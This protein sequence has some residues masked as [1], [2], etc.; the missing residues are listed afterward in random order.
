MTTRPLMLSRLLALLI[1]SWLLATTTP[2]RADIVPSDDG[3]LGTTM[4]LPSNALVGPAQKA[5]GWVY[6]G[7]CEQGHWTRRLF[8]NLPRCDRPGGMPGFTI[9][10]W[11]GSVVRL[12]PYG[13]P[14][15]RLSAGYTAKL[16]ST[17][18]RGSHVWGEITI[19]NIRLDQAQQSFGYV[20]MGTCKD[21]RWLTQAFRFMPLCL[22][23][24]ISDSPFFVGGRLVVSVADNPV[25]LHLPTS[26]PAA[27]PVRDRLSTLRAGRTAILQTVHDLGVIDEPGVHHFW[28]EIRFGAD[29]RRSQVV[30]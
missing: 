17:Q 26:G 14:I 19:E 21:G 16:I 9:T 5:R 8:S 30:K 1:A 7:R 13:F 10:A 24:F 23:S 28:G 25:Y 27:P 11:N 2:A 22:S 18:L 4:A 12:T 6:L 15:G 20:H 3:L 29:F